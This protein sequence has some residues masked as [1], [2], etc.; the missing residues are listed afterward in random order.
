MESVDLSLAEDA[1]G[2]IARKA[3]ERKTGARGLRSIM[4]TS[5][6]APCLICRGSKASKKW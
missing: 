4:P 3:I 1:L 5:C 2:T 6:S